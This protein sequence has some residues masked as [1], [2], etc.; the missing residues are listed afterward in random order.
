MTYQL[1]K[2]SSILFFVLLTIYPL[3]AVSQIRITGAVAASYGDWT[4]GDIVIDDNLCV[5]R[6]DSVD[7]YKV[8]I[9]DDSTITPTGFYLENV[10][11]TSEVSVEVRWNNAPITGGAAITDNKTKN[12]NS[13][14]EVD[15]LCV[16]GGDS[17]NLQITITGT[18]LDALPPGDYSTELNVQVEPR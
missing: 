15:E 10:P 1:P 12:T 6:D 8:L 4:T 14:N 7:R 13:A 5:Y 17:A 2:E 18:D 9:T 11:N 16:T 3:S